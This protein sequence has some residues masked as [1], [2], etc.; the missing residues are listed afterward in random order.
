MCDVDKL[1]ILSRRFLIVLKVE[2]KHVL[3]T[4]ATSEEWKTEINAMVK[5]INEF[6]HEKN[7]TKNNTKAHN[8]Y[9]EI[10]HNAYLQFRQPRDS[11]YFQLHKKMIQMYNE[12]KKMPNHRNQLGEP[13]PYMNKIMTACKSKG[14]VL[15]HCVMAMGIAAMALQAA[16]I[17]N[18][19][20]RVIQEGRQRG[21]N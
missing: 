17:N 14:K 4:K 12:C 1:R 11:I 18:Q 5:H 3:K 6:L 13:R 15:S 21:W 20:R 2:L 16:C 9:V 8:Y 7:N 10:G 19:V